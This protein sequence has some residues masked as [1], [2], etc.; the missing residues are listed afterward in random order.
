MT[1]RVTLNEIEIAE[2]IAKLEVDAANRMAHV[3]INVAQKIMQ[4]EATMAWA[5][6]K[7]Q[8]RTQRFMKSTKEEVTS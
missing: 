1:N 5:E 7:L 2:K 8:S 4:A 6:E 3:E